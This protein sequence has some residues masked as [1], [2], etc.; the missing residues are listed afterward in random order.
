[1]LKRYLLVF[2]SLVGLIAPAAFVLALLVAPPAH[3]QP[4]QPPGCERDLAD[5]STGVAVAFKISMNS[6]SVL[7]FVP[8]S[9]G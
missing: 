6:S 4:L 9:G 1:M 8:T 2:P 5:A 3:P 7:S